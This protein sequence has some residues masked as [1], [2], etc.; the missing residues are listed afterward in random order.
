MQLTSSVISTQIHSRVATNVYIE[1]F[2]VRSWALLTAAMT[3]LLLLARLLTLSA[4]VQALTFPPWRGVRQVL[5]IGPWGGLLDALPSDNVLYVYPNGTSKA[6]ASSD[7]TPTPAGHRRIVAIS[8][9]HGKHRFITVPP[10]DI[11]CHCGDILQ[12][13]GYLGGLGGGLPALMDFASWLK[14]NV[15]AQHSVVIGGNH[16]RLLEKLG[17]GTVRTILRRGGATYLRD[18]AATV[19]GLVFWGSPW[20]PSG[21]TGNR[22]FQRGTCATEEAAHALRSTMSSQGAGE[23]RI[24]VLLTHAA[25]SAWETVVSAAAPSLWLHGHWHDGQG[26]VKVVGNNCISVNVASNDMIYRPVHPAVVFDLT[27]PR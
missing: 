4:A 13:Y 1:M 3:F 9:T 27:C 15:P 8:D 25:D 22:A 26:H 24:D 17:D 10:C 12:R 16:D 11:L 6:V 23:G 21:G 20:S 14:H 2:H 19:A 5:A 18:E 7:L